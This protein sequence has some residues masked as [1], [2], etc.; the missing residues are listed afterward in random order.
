MN[1]SLAAACREFEA[2]MLRQLLSEAGVG[3]RAHMGA[4]DEDAADGTSRDNLMQAFFVDAM[5][6]ALAR[7]SGLGIGRELARSL[8]R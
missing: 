2:G 7:G 8:E 1:V 6:S 5:A 3:K 4:D